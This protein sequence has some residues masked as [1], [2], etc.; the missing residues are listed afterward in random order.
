MLV[1]VVLFLS[2]R[3]KNYQ[4]GVM[5]PLEKLFWA[6]ETG[7]QKENPTPGPRDPRNTQTH[8]SRGNY[9]LKFS[10]IGVTCDAKVATVEWNMRTSGRRLHLS[11]TRARNSG[12][13]FTIHKRA[14]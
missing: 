4:H 7:T 13:D 9:I 11:Q 14:S 5:F 2:C 8:I 3:F 6:S 12:S 1:Y 10:K